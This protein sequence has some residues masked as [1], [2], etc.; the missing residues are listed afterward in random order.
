MRLRRACPR[1][2]NDGHG[3]A[4]KFSGVV[5]R[6]RSIVA[7]DHLDLEVSRGETLALLGPNGA[8]KS[9]A[10]SI[11][12]GLQRPQ[13]GEVSVL[14]TDPRSAMA[15]GAVGAMLQVGGG[16]GLPHG[17]KV[18]DLVA[19]TSRLYRRP[20]PVSRTL[21]RAGL[22]DLADRPTQRLSG[23]QAQRV[24]FALAI[25]GD[26][27]LVFLDEPTI[28]MDVE[29]RRSFW[30]MMRSFSQEGRTVVFA[31]HH[32]DEVAAVADRIVVMRR[33]T[34]VA[35]GCASTIKA[36]VPTRRVRFASPGADPARLRELDGVDAACLHGSQVVLDSLDADAT[37]RALVS[38]GVAF[39]DI[40][41]TGADLEQAFVALTGDLA[42][43][44]TV[45]DAMARRQAGTP[46][47]TIPLSETAR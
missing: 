15:S 38:S 20:S 23:G 47:A 6:Y 18:G 37:V 43:A 31:T 25:A 3:P 29:G 27:E 4:L 17:V 11:L 32:L 36:A 33:G 45:D 41:V 44:Q 35:N 34:V 46:G 21:A 12:L 16:S 42:V 22:T 40:E 2:Q 28:A 26:P 39:S 1:P 7:L 30:A 19:M 5:H 14:G 9:T 8:G 24:R 13:E 10:I